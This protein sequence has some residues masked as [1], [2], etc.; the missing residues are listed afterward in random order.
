MINQK[1]DTYTKDGLKANLREDTQEIKKD[2]ESLKGNIVGLAHKAIDSG[3][4]SVADVREKAGAQMD[5]LRAAGAEG[6]KKA[7]ERVREKPGQSIAVAFIAGILI[8][9]IFGRK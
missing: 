6:M 3:A 7:E 4:D 5:R 8:N 9:A 2:I 1:P